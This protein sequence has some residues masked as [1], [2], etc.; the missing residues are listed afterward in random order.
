MKK[1]MKTSGIPLRRIV[2]AVAIPFCALGAV[3][4]IPEPVAITQDASATFRDA[5]A[6]RS[7]P[8]V[9]H[10]YAHSG[11][12]EFFAVSA[13]LREKCYW[14]TYGNH[15]RGKIESM[16]RACGGWF[17]GTDFN[18]DMDGAF[19]ICGKEYD[20]CDTLKPG[21]YVYLGK[22]RSRTW[23]L[24]EFVWE[25]PVYMDESLSRAEKK[26]LLANFKR[27]MVRLLQD[28]FSGKEAT[29]IENGVF[30]KGGFLTSN[31]QIEVL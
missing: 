18:E 8:V 10:S 15:E 3:I 27:D 28:E 2:A 17:L 12:T 19:V 1:V 4:A 24:K 13:G 11:K 14:F 7:R 31:C 25:R 6:D 26:D 22:I 21:R 9:G 23:F 5:V 20:F 16:A 30:V 29:A